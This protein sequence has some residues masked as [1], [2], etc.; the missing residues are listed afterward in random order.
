MLIFHRIHPYRND[1]IGDEDKGS[2]KGLTK[3]NITGQ[4]TSNCVS[5]K[6]TTKQRNEAESGVGENDK[7]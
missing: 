1:S 7:H 4:R 5:I 3:G 2:G 6:E